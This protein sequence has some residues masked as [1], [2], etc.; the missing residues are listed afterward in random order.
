M[1]PKST[2]RAPARTEPAA[3]R[4]HGTIA[5]DIGIRIV[6]GVYQPGDILNGEVAASDELRVSR[7]AYREAV[8]ILAAKGLVESR[9][10]VGT[11]VSARAQWHLLD[12][13]VLSWIFTTEPAEALVTGLFELRKI[14]EPEAAA[15]AAARRSDEQLAIMAAALKDM[16]FHTLATPAGRD[17]D[18]EF[19][20][21]LLDASRNPFLISLTSG[22]AAAVAWTTVFKQR[23]NPLR[24]NPIPDHKRVYDAIAAGDSGAARAA[25]A[26]LVDMAYLDTRRSQRERAARV[27]PVGE[28]AS[29]ET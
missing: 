3:L 7:T 1:K 5:R 19:H 14:V 23:K 29:L 2:S 24:R 13:D 15:L 25:M 8:R 26:K 11:R 21:A 6:S 9:P 22:V 12:P 17:A 28:R 10:K 4:L 18:Q 27:E 16:A 20:S